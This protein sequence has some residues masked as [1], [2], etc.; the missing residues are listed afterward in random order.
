MSGL[1]CEFPNGEKVFYIMGRGIVLALND[2]MGVTH[3]LG[4]VWTFGFHEHTKEVQVRGIEKMKY[5][6][7]L[8]LCFGSPF[9]KEE[10]EQIKM[11]NILITRTIKE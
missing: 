9:C 6:K 7:P 10:L 5:A 11:G 8:G 2:D 3:K 4:D 1:L